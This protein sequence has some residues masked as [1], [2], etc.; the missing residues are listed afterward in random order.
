MPSRRAA[1]HPSPATS[2]VHCALL[3]VLVLGPAIPLRARAEEAPPE[4]ATD[5]GTSPEPLA[6]AGTPPNGAA[7]ATAGI[8]PAALPG[9]PAG[10][11][12]LPS[13]LQ[14]SHSHY[15]VDAV[16]GG[17]AGITV[18][19]P[20]AVP[21]IGADAKYEYQPGRWLIVGA[22]GSATLGGDQKGYPVCGY[23]ALA[24]AGLHWVDTDRVS[25]DSLARAGLGSALCLPAPLLG[26]LHRARVAIVNGNSFQWVVGAELETDLLYPTLSVELYS[27]LL[28]RRGQF[29]MGPRLVAVGSVALIP[30]GVY[31]SV[32]G[33][34]VFSW[35]F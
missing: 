8:P 28:Y 34:L 20:Y 2:R 16:L 29:K 17:A 1:A 15:S 25:L 12:Y 35:D 10:L 18:V 22:H 31:A 5:A 9:P 32:T 4:P 27:G 30:P 11:V 13:P 7:P 6:D 21:L 24:V 26:L 33:Q 23:S 19:A 14:T 3:A